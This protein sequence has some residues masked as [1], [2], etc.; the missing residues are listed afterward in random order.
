MIDRGT[1]P[2]Q[3][4]IE[5]F[6]ALPRDPKP[7]P[8][9]LDFDQELRNLLTRFMKASRFSRAEI[10]ARMTDLVFGDAGDGEITKAQLDSWTAPSRSDWR[11]PACYLPAFVIAV[12]AYELLG[13]IADKC[14]CRV[15][16]GKEV[17][18]AELGQIQR[19][20]QELNEREKALK[21]AM[22]KKR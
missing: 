16:V 13:A 12:D 21:K 17:L 2:R 9:S 7:T 14:R 4:D 1:P 10:A 11:F 15:L 22:G 18:D 3:L 20:K 5:D 19:Q 8:G 6:I